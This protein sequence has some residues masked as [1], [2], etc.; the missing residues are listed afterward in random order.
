MIVVPRHG[1]GAAFERARGPHPQQP[2]VEAGKRA[3]AEIIALQQKIIN[4]EPVEENESFILIRRRKITLIKIINGKKNKP[5]RAHTAIFF[6]EGFL[7]FCVKKSTIRKRAK[8]SMKTNR[9]Q[10]VK[11][12]LFSKL[13]GMKERT[14]K[15]SEN[16]PLSSQIIR[17]LL[18]HR[19]F[20][21]VFATTPLARKRQ[22]FQNAQDTSSFSV[23]LLTSMFEGFGLHLG[24]H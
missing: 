17:F 15:A 22:L 1:L 11:I 6:K 7:F 20:S 8:L 23:S 16:A 18:C 21:V 24:L 19:S 9:R 4:G 10:T 3:A 13:V 14:L 2:G 5:I 12:K